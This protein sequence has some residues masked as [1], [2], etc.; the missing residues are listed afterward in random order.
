M[1]DINEVE[2]QANEEIKKSV[3]LM[4]FL[5]INYLLKSLFS[6]LFCDSDPLDWAAVKMD[7]K[8]KGR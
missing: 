8:S 6:L 2:F 3:R 1:K 7:S 5:S 4:I